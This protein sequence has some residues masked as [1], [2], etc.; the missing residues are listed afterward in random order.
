MHGVEPGGAQTST[1]GVTLGEQARASVGGRV[2][3]MRT[4]YRPGNNS[5]MPSRV[6]GGGGKPS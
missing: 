2:S 6:I 4:R 5:C 1:N 3:P